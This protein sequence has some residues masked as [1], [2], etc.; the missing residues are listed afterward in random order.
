LLLLQGYA[1]GQKKFHD[2]GRSKIAAEAVSAYLVWLQNCGHFPMERSTPMTSAK[3]S[4]LPIPLHALVLLAYSLPC[5]TVALTGCGSSK[6]GSTTTPPISGPGVSGPAVWVANGTNVLEFN[7]TVNSQLTPPADTPTLTLNSSAFSR[8]QGVAFDGYGN[9]WVVDGGN[10]NAQ[11]GNL[12]RPA[13][14]QFPAAS[15]AAQPSPATATPSVTISSSTFVFPQQAVFDSQ[16]NL[17]VADG[18]ANAIFKFTPS[19]LS[20][21]NSSMTPALTVLS[22][23]AFDSGYL[24]SAGSTL[25]IAFDAAGGLWVANNGNDKLYAFHAA[26]FA[27]AS[28]SVTLPPDVVLS[29]DGKQSIAW[30][31]GLAFD[32][33]GNLWVSNAGYF[34]LLD[35][36]IAPVNTVVEFPKASLATTGSPTPTMILTS[37]T[38][39]GNTSLDFP[40]GIAFG[41]NGN[42]AVVSSGSPQGVNLFSSSQLSS[43]AVAPITFI[44]SASSFNKPASVTFGPLI[45]YGSTSS[46]GM[47]N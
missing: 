38:V 24:R 41:S 28:G 31:W 3:K 17:W 13:L 27:T 36:L 10:L 47:M 44:G 22:N 23:P 26:S 46:S 40:E 45:S 12:S 4:N 19:Q 33:T 18:G 20:A 2:K 39:N 32:S 15:L 8:P 42:L 37:T 34:G 21:S 7:P 1:A 25:G 9:L 14:Y 35:N 6:S 11:A 5:L 16:G 30:P 43:G 29:D